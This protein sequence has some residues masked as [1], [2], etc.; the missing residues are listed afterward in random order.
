MTTQSSTD[1]S[2]QIKTQCKSVFHYIKLSM[3]TFQKTTGTIKSFQ[4]SQCG[5]KFHRLE[6]HRVTP[7]K[8]H[9]VLPKA[10]T[11][12]TSVFATNSAVAYHDSR[13]G[14][15]HA[16]KPQANL[17][18]G[19]SNLFSTL[20]YC[21]RLF[22]RFLHWSEHRLSPAPRTSS[23]ITAAPLTCTPAGEWRIGIVSNVPNKQQTWHCS[24]AFP[25]SCRLGRQENSERLKN[26]FH[27]PS[28]EPRANSEAH[29]ALRRQPSTF[30][31]SF[32]PKF[33]PPPIPPPP[34]PGSV[35]YRLV[36]CCRE[37]QFPPEAVRGFQVEG[38]RQVVRQQ[39]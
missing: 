28:P 32:Q 36:L 37:L 6:S 27:A 12:R 19:S 21:R 23:G 26:T 14:S 30:T 34:R 25:A 1:G 24:F 10:E 17:R 4:R 29:L 2:T 3:W 8:H 22:R 39:G 35:L 11:P 33:W 15:H 16:K 13:C 7:P 20:E 9:A 38:V 18:H 5:L 31:V